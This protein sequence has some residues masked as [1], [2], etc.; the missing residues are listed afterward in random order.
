ME[1]SSASETSLQTVTVVFWLNFLQ[2]RL[3]WV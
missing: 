3:G 2:H 1:L